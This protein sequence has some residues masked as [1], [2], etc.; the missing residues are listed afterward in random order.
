MAAVVNLRQS[1]DRCRALRFKW[2]LIP[3]SS[4]CASKE[5][6]LLAGM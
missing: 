3:I 2:V 5:E 1:A 6:V 4:F